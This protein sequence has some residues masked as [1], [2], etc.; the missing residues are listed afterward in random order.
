MIAS[1]T[2]LPFVMDMRD[3]WSDAS[4]MLE[5]MNSSTWKRLAREHEDRCVAAADRV[6]VTSKAHASLQEAKYPALRGRVLTVMNGADREPIPTSDPGNRFVVAFAGMIYLGRNPRSL[7][8]AAARVARETG[9]RPEEFGVE[10][11]GDESCDGVPLTTIATEEGLGPYFRSYP[12]RPRAQ[13]MSFLSRASVLVS[14]PLRT[15]MTLPAKLFEY[16]RF[17]A[18]LLVLAEPGSA[19]AE[20]LSETTADVAAPEDVDAMA[21]ALRERFEDFRRGVRPVSINRDGRFDR[22]TQAAHLYDGLDAVV[23]PAGHLAGID[24]SV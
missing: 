13:A 19:T 7:F 1:Q 15:V 14:L 12:F 5:E 18:W 8:R 9:A 3:P 17:D 16:I 22:A 11:L 10:F 4:A 20:L 2:S 23:A 24:H 6:V 21:R